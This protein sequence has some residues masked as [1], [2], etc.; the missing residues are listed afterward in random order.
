MKH[1]Y[2]DR[3][4]FL[5]QETHDSTKLIEQYNNFIRKYH[6]FFSQETVDLRFHDIRCFFAM[7]ADKDKELANN[8]RGDTRYLSKSSIKFA[9]KVFWD[10]KFNLRKHSPDDLYSELLIPFLECAT[11]YRDM[12]K[13]FHR[14]LYATY[15]KKLYN[16][17]K[18]H[19]KLDAIDKFK[20]SFLDALVYETPDEEVPDELM[21]EFDEGLELNDPDWIHGKKAEA[22]FDDLKAH[23]RFILAKYYYEEYKDREIAR[24]LPY[25]PK[26]INRIRMR[27]K[28]K[29]IE[30]YREG[31]FKWIRAEHLLHPSS[32][33]F[34]KA[35]K[36]TFIS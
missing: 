29:F 22:P 35:G 23:E 25:D 33:L 1:T 2:P 19:I 15:H 34:V 12:G 31:E 16:Y 3:N 14:Y 10:I 20:T 11:E 27:I 28:K 24:M 26:S 8:L 36:A 4:V 21:V 17:L 13:G 9:T 6:I 32:V 5:Y 30:R 7:Y 18:Y